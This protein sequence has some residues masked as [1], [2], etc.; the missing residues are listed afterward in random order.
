VAE[1]LEAAVVA[2]GAG[3]AGLA[4]AVHAAE[5]G[6]RVLVL[7]EAGQPG[8]SIWR[9][10]TGSARRGA[11][12]WLDRLSRSAASVVA[13]ASVVDAPEARTLLV[14]RGG[15]PLVVRYEQLVLA[16]GARELFLP[17]PGGTLPGVVGV[18]GAQA[19]AKSGASFR[20]LRVVVAGTGPLLLAAAATLRAGGAR[21]VGIVEQA[22]LARLTSFVRHV[23]A[24][25]RKLIEGLGYA[26]RLAGVPYRTGAWVLAATG[27]ERVERVSVGD[28]RREREWACDVL[29]CGYGLVANLE[30]PRLLGCE[31]RGGR[32]VVDES[33]RTSQP[34]VFAAGELVGVGGVEHA[35]VTGAIAGRAAAGG[36]PPP[37]LVGGFRRESAFA[38]ALARAFAPRDELRSLARADTTL[39]RC[40]DV[41][42]GAVDEALSGP[43]TVASGDVLRL[44]KLHTRAGMGACQGRLCGAALAFLRGAE[45]PA[46]RPPLVPTPLA[47]LA[48]ETDEPG[49]AASREEAR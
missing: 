2:V 45:T 31:T 15:S 34:L 10:G 33:M 41:P 21:L 20:G 37:A 38:D 8:G 11:G 49:A 6:A 12:P 9:G 35:L 39:C 19:M 23:V 18:G 43:G 36:D 27:R 40:E 24:R 22:P 26:A 17:F 7:D 5:A 4:A 30:L 1:R 46:G 28:G 29:A 16:T 14:D 42:L 25:P 3:P 32:V 48:G 47:V 13:G 44:L